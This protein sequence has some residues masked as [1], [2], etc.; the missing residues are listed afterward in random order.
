MK[1]MKICMVS[2]RSLPLYDESYDHEHVIGGA[3]I[4]LYN[5]AWC[6]SEIANVEVKVLVDDFGQPSVYKKGNIEL[7]KYGNRS[8]K[9]DLY[10]RIAAKIACNFKLLSIDADAFIFTTGNPLLGKL[11]LF[12]QVL[13]GKKVIFR[14]SSDLNIDL[15]HFQKS[16][17]R[18]SYMLY[19]FGIC[20]ASNIIS[21]TQ[22]QKNDLESGLGLKSEMIE[23]G[24]FTNRNIDVIEKKHILWVG[25]CM[26]S[27]QPMLFVE[28]ARRMPEEE[29]VMIMPIN[30]EIPAGE[31]KEREELAHAVLG[32]AQRLNNIQVIDY[33][34]YQDI[35]AY[36]DR[37][38]A[39]V[40][41]SDTEGFPN[42]FIQAALGGTP[43]LSYN[44]N[45]DGMIEKYHLGYV[46]KEGPEKAVE[47]LR[48][49]DNK[50][51]LEYKYHMF[52]YVIQKH[53]IY[54]AA[55]KYLNIID[56]NSEFDFYEKDSFGISNEEG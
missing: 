12:Q 51:L 43:I 17:S 55:R 33:V 34:A 3:E 41:T 22:K 49:I 56:V 2:L 39:Y 30:K 52:N 7:I 42:T 19:K 32:S 53:N 38:K 31:Y 24:F 11:V 50:I 18:L 14:L 1:K 26:K 23:N 9:R 36:F 45:P 21:Q 46:C 4:N 20:H 6:L 35:Q 15:E 16:N 8:G 48:E 40:C 27:K 29:F 47:F 54:H 37:A 13:R 10:S 5:L 44:M 28:L 25:R